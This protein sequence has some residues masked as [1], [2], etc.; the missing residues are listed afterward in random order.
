MLD[1]DLETNWKSVFE[2]R[3]F[4]I[5]HLGLADERLF[6]SKRKHETQLYWALA[7]LLAG[8]SIQF[9]VVDGYKLLLSF[10]A[11]RQSLFLTVD[12]KRKRH[13]LGWIDPCPYN[14]LFRFE[15][16]EA[17]ARIGADD[18]LHAHTRF[19][20][21][22]GFWGLSKQDLSNVKAIRKLLTRHIKA[23]G[24]F[25]KAEVEF[26]VEQPL[27]RLDRE[28]GCHWIQHPKFGW[29]AESAMSLRVPNSID[30]SENVKFNFSLFKS[31]TDSLRM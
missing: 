6:R 26:I 29:V 24:L 27:Q 16:L 30:V 31:F 15:E 10:E 17:I 20:L 21:L 3:E 18:S 14:K 23:T 1:P 22:S 28:T 19:L 25:S 9:S 5:I 13:L 7:D 8:R 11:G 4:W 2:C 12:G